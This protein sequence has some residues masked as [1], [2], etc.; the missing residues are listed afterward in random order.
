MDNYLPLLV[1]TVLSGLAAGSFIVSLAYPLALGAK[2]EAKPERP[3]THLSLISLAALGIGLLASL[4]HLGQPLRFINGL[5]N[6]GSMISQESYWGIALLVLLAACVIVSLIKKSL[7]FVLQVATALAGLG[8]IAVSSLAYYRAIGIPSWSDA[9]TISLL[10]FGDLLLGASLCAMMFRSAAAKD[11][12]LKATLGLLFVNLVTLCAFAI[13]ISGLPVPSQLGYLVG[14]S[15]VGIVAPAVLVAISILG[16]LHQAKLAIVAF[17]LI[18]IGVVLL[19]M[20]FFAS[21]VHL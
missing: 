5:S 13:H 3:S 17:V 6:P 11:R 10:V 12:Y 9:S 20:A 1:F 4:L 19:R 15:I 21:G 2:A 14:A 18:A 7:P 8:L 16:K